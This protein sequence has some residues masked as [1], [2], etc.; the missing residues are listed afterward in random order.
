MIESVNTCT[1]CQNL[2]NNFK[3]LKHDKDVELNNTC[4]S[5]VEQNIFLDKNS[6][7]INCSFYKLNSCKHPERAGYGMLCFSWKHN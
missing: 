2:T 1:N 3:C 4:E 6:S 7:C 5:H